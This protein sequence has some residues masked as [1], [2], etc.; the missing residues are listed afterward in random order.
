MALPL[1]Q[2]DKDLLLSA[3]GLP[4]TRDRVVALLDLAGTG[5]MTGP[6]ISTDNAIVRFDGSTGALVQNSGIFIDDSNNLS[7]IAQFS[8]SGQIQ[9]ADGLVSAPGISFTLDPDTGDYRIGSGSMGRAA[10][11]VRIGSHNAA[12][13]W[14]FGVGAGSTPLI[15]EIVVVGGTGMATTGQT[16][17]RCQPLFSSAATTEINGIV[18]AP[19][20]AAAVFNSALYLGVFSQDVVLG[21]GSTVT[22]TAMFFANDPTSATNNA[23]LSD[24][25]GF[26]GNYFINYGGSR[27]S[28]IAGQVRVASL[29]VANSTAATTPGT[30]TRKIEIFD[31]SGASLGF[32]AVYDAIT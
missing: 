3:L 20:T 32:V 27:P 28:A 4:E 17:I 16:A 29:G 21:A 19:T 22:R 31:A 13:N 15:S 24:N 26:I 12:G 10:N 11:S 2:R 25:V 18:I 9:A 1:T 7:G 5:N 30:V 23:I 8:A 14:G 6:A